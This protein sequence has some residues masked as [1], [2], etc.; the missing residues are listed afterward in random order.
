MSGL[1]GVV[2]KVQASGARTASEAS[3][4]GGID[5]EEDSVLLGFAEAL[6]EREEVKAND[7]VAAVH[8][9]R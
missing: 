5:S 9:Q 7:E 1:G 6:M 3:Q 8:E 4:R 2:H